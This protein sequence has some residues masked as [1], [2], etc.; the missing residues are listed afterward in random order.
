MEELIRIKEIKPEIS[1]EDLTKL[2]IR[3]CKIESVEKVEKKNKL[4]KLLINTGID[5]RVVISGIAENFTNED[6]SGKIFPF[7][8]N[9][10]PRKI[11]GIESFGMI[12]LAEDA[13][14]GLLKVVPESNDY[15]IGAILI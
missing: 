9:L 6:L 8:L 13:L 7:V 11:A 10:P 12:I 1:F 15:G 3:L 2:D 4:Y 14:S 5:K